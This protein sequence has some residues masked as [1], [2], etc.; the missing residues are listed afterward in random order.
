MTVTVTVKIYAYVSAY[1][2]P[3]EIS[4]ELPE[5]V[6]E[7]VNQLLAGPCSKLNMDWGSVNHLLINGRNYH[8][9]VAEKTKL[10][11][12]DILSFVSMFCGG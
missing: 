2:G 8:L 9:A 3:R 5:D 10:K 7:A 12:G 6:A 4:V 1:D 11:D